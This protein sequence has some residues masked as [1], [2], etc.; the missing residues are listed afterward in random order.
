MITAAGA[1]AAVAA[2]SHAVRHGDVLYCSGQI[3][4]DP[5]A[6]DLVGDSAAEQTDRCLR[7]LEAVCGASGT[8]LNRALRLTIYTTAM[9][10]FAAINEVYA[11]FFVD[12][13]PARAAVGVTSLP[14]G[15]AVMIDAIVAVGAK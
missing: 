3:A 4:L 11:G 2:Y 7:N 8:G 14:R 10:E 15:A 6:G 13:P 12:A 1:P 5:D 9:D